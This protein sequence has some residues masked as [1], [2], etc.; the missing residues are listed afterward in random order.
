MALLAPRIS[1]TAIWFKYASV[2]GCH[3]QGFLWLKT[4][5]RSLPHIYGKANISIKLELSKNKGRICGVTNLTPALEAQVSQGA[6]LLWSQFDPL[7][8]CER[9]QREAFEETGDLEGE[10][11]G[12][13]MGK[14]RVWAGL[15]KLF[16]C[17]PFP[18]LGISHTR[19]RMV[20][21]QKRTLV[22]LRP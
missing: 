14:E 22:G 13:H 1:I 18:V 5:G 4:R 19:S 21:A 10:G 17:L 20:D 3:R 9:K 16:S 8:T 6:N 15:S 11:T 2:L 12:G 7:V